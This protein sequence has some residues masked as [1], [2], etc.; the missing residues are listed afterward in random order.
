MSHVSLETGGAS[1]DKEI[2]P[3]PL[4]QDCLISGVAEVGNISNKRLE[5][6]HDV[7][8]VITAGR[9]TGSTGTNKL[10]LY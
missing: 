7:A 1:R 6:L 3:P 5:L 8:R 2:D 9:P 10:L 4:I